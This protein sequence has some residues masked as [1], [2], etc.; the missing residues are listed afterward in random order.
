M[1]FSVNK[2]ELSDAL[3]V[4]AKFLGKGSHVNP[5]IKCFHLASDGDTLTITATDT[6]QSAQITIPLSGDKG[7]V[8]VDGV[9]IVNA[10]S[11]L[12]ADGVSFVGDAA[13][14]TIKR[15][16]GN[17]K[18]RITPPDKFPNCSFGKLYPVGFKGAE[19]LE[20][21]R[22]AL[23]GTDDDKTV[24]TSR[25]A[26]FSIERN[27]IE[28]KFTCFTTDGHRLAFLNGLCD[29]EE[30]EPFK[31]IIPVYAF[32]GLVGALKGSEKLAIGQ[33]KNHIFVESENKKFSFLKSNSQPQNIQPYLDTMV[34]D[35]IVKVDA[36]DLRSSLELVGAF[37]GA[38]RAF[39]VDLNGE[40]ILS[41]QNA[42]TGEIK[43]AIE[44]E[45][46][47]EEFQTAYGL[48]YVLPIIRHI[49]G[50]TEIRFAKDVRT[51]KDATGKVVSE[52][53]GWPMRVTTFRNNVTSSFDVMSRTR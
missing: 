21:C 12:K 47:F 48:D 45:F 24:P 14:L 33:D 22:A 2:K 50:E 19:F 6:D 49:E 23:L 38:S 13:S 16:E 10:I 20:V 5:I 53:I 51:I 8:C 9:T 43:E 29:T 15:T 7:E 4:A 26:T 3:G 25:I 44:T 41:A 31:I 42:D 27:L 28:G 35:R 36:D 18:L 40:L 32:R 11:R 1:K 17:I 46:D 34:F 39:Y 37:V 30:A 52:T